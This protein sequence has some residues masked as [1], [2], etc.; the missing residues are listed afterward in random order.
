MSRPAVW[1]CYRFGH[2]SRR[3]ICRP[4]E[5]WI[6]QKTKLGYWVQ[7][8]RN[9]W[10][11]IICYDHAL[12]GSFLAVYGRYISTN[13]LLLPASSIDAQPLGFSQWRFSESFPKS[14]IW[15]MQLCFSL[16][17]LIVFHCTYFLLH[18]SFRIRLISVFSINMYFVLLYL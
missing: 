16:I 11:N 17:V 7:W 15:L 8:S 13:I 5:W 9:P 14:N 18:T 12:S 1:L 4:G 6:L 3:Y 10:E 2:S